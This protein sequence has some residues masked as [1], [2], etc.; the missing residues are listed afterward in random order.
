MDNNNYNNNN[1]VTITKSML[2]G[3]S[4]KIK[5]ELTRHARCSVWSLEFGGLRL[6]FELLDDES[7]ISWTMDLWDLLDSLAGPAGLVT[8]L[9]Q[10]VNV[11]LQAYSSGCGDVTLEHH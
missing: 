4:F 10:N 5:L 3:V 9:K 11:L 2:C 1:K 7:W 8:F 6:E